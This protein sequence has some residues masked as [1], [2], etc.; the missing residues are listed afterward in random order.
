MS[1]TTSWTAKN[2][3]KKTI[4][5]GRSARLLGKALDLL[6]SFRVQ[7]LMRGGKCMCFRRL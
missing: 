2:K 7:V 5:F 4:G 6:G 1:K 3:T